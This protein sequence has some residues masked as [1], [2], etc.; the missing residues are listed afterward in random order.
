MAVI[1]AALMLT[2][3]GLWDKCFQADAQTVVDQDRFKE[4][5]LYLGQEP[6]Y[7]LYCP[8]E[9]VWP[10]STPQLD[11]VWLKDSVHL[12]NKE[13]RT[14]LDLPSLG[15]EDQGNYTCMEKDND[16][17]SFTVR[18]IVREA[19]CSQVPKYH[20]DGGLT[21]LWGKVGS[22]V[23]MNCTALLLRATNEE[24]CNSTLQWIKDG[25][26]LT[27]DTVYVQNTSSW[28]PGDG[29]LLVSS[30]LV[31]TI[32]EL[33][34]F[35]LYSCTM[36]NTS[37]DFSLQNASSPSHTAAVIAAIVLLLLLA[38]AVI[39]YS[40]CHLNIKLWYR[41]LYGDYEINDGKL[42]DAYISYVNNDYDRK[43]VNFILKPHLEKSGYKLHLNSNDILPGSEPPAELLMSM[44]RSRRL[45]VVLSYA[46]LEQDWCSNDF[47]QGL[48]HLLQL[49]QQPMLILLEGQYKRMRSE[50]KKQLSA[51][52][53]CLTILT[54][55][56]NS[57]TPSSTFWKEL[58]L[59]MP[60]HVSIHR[61]SAG[62]PQ[63]VLQDDKDPMLTLNPDYLD[64]SSDTDPAG[65]LGLHLPMYKA[66][67]RKAPVLPAAPIT[68][69]EPKPSDIDVSDLGSRNYGTRS[70]FYHLVT[71]QDV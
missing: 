53:H 54:W 14:Y 67:S 19:P 56:H 4:Q 30:L 5:V 1:L 70:D 52:Q 15:F 33:D 12:H 38:V 34:D 13:G 3:S 55:R 2:C 64:C 32:R 25:K 22:T 35:G 60:R 65:D 6:P 29:H 21:S 18:L 37:S 69:P 49:C 42:Y 66:L 40:K 17:T 20:P 36:R 47:R 71:E 10:Q 9:S 58:A 50:I 39:V 43:F 11:I 62:D 59:A 51:H 26:P 63:T 41:N 23:K 44:S 27:N 7:R 45:I 31:I 68:G 24:Q 46:Y 28:S 61:A 8:I 48:L 16:T 57:V